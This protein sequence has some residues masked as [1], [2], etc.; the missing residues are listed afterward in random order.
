M[1]TRTN[2]SPPLQQDRDRPPKS[3]RIDGSR[4]FDTDVR[5]NSL[6]HDTGR[7]A[8]INSEESE[9]INTHGSER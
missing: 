2:E 4:N 3:N 1:P 6:N 9:E 5:N 8:P 7:D